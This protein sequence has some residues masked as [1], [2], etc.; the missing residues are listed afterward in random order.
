MRIE[1]V[2][3]RILEWRE[4]GCKVFEGG[5]AECEDMWVDDD[6]DRQRIESSELDATSVRDGICGIRDM[7]LEDDRDQ[8]TKNKNKTIENGR[9]PE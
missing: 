4:W 8:Q 3:G 6:C 9:N 7:W 1:S 5:Y 2:H